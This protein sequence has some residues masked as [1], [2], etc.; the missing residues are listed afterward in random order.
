MT[1]TRRAREG[2]AEQRDAVLP[3]AVV[4]SARDHRLLGGLLPTDVGVYR[5]AWGHRCGRAAGAEQAIFINCTRGSGWC[6]IF[7]RRV[8]AGAGELLVIPP[9][10]PHVYGADSVRPWTIHWFHAQGAYTQDFLEELGVSRERCVFRL[11]NDEHLT[12]LHAEVMNALEHG[13]GPTQLLYASHAL[14]HLICAMIRRQRE[15]WAGE[16]GSVQRVAESI[17]YMKQHLTKPLNVATL[18]S[19]TGLSPSHYSAVFKRQTGYAPIDYFNRL[20]IQ[21]ACQLLVATQHSIKTIGAMLGYSDPLYFSRVFR[22]VNEV[23]PRYYRQ[24]K[25]G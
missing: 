25:Q 2:F 21:R 23:S 4:A 1:R 9:G 5:E 10:T 19:L 18:S 20:R 17:T 6:E 3:R 7:G 12:G 15:N 11:G 16:P 22:A 14:A 13:Y 8:S 24:L